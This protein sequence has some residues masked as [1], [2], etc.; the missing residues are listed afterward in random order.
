MIPLSATSV[1]GGRKLAADGTRPCA[2]PVARVLAA[3]SLR[4][5]LQNSS[6]R[7]PSATHTEAQP[8]S[9]GVPACG[10]SV[11]S[12]LR[13]SPGRSDSQIT[14]AQRLVRA[15]RKIKAAGIPYRI[16]GDA[17]SP[18][19]LGAVL[20]VVYLVFNEGFCVRK[21]AISCVARSLKHGPQGWGPV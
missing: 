10:Y 18:G 6:R 17:E 9:A 5:T 8:R 15:K 7:G 4:T 3:L 11:A 16:P 13:R 1:A 2:G 21:R 19:R 20:A 12:R 14:M